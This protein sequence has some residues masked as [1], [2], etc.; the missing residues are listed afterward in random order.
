[1]DVSFAG[2]TIKTKEQA[3]TI[4]RKKQVRKK[5]KERRREEFQKTKNKSR[6]RHGFLPVVLVMFCR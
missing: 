6:K 3:R 1:M 5:Y 4:K 2:F